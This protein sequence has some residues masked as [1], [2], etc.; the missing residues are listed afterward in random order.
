[1]TKPEIVAAH[2]AN[3][4]LRRGSE[5]LPQAVDW[6]WDGW[7]AAS[8]LHLIGGAPGT[9][10]TTI[11]V[12]LAAAITC[13]GTW[14]DG[15]RAKAGNV[16]IWSGEDD[17]RVTLAPRLHA[18]GADMDRVFFVEGVQQGPERFPF[19]PAKDMDALRAALRDIPD[20]QLVV[21]D[22]IVS[23]VAKDSHNNGDVRRGLQPLVDLG[24]EKGAAVLGITHFSK[25]TQGREP[26][27]RVTGSLAFGALARLVMVTVKQE[28]EVDRPERRILVRAKSNIGPDGG[29]F[30]YGLKQVELTDFP[31]VCASKVAWRESIHGTARALLAAAEQPLDTEPDTAGDA[32]E[33]LRSSLAHG[34]R[35]VRDLKAEASSAGIAWRTI[36]RHKSRAGVV[37]R[38]RSMGEGWEWYI[39]GITAGHAPKAAEDTR[40]D[41]V[42]SFGDLLQ[43]TAT[44][45]DEA[46]ICREDF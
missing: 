24:M 32:V 46:L 4:I 40:S 14:P 13:G 20:I 30:V 37:S 12:A 9:G 19:D 25:G 34:P 8:M 17:Y 43:D 2:A 7:L 33:F 28:A 16:L 5:V 1:M 3:A 45:G 27:E 22:P 11:A 35:A 44:D 26:L 41:G 31:E 10:K 23:A 38:K 42:A 6:L 18:A 15:T 21:I 29:G 39:K 36:Q